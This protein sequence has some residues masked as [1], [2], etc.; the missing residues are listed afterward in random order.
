MSKA[1]AR[2]TPMG[3]EVVKREE[4]KSEA[5]KVEEPTKSP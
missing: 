4:N 5:A 2:R 1:A 3:R